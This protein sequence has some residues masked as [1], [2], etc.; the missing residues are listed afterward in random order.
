M[1]LGSGSRGSQRRSTFGFVD[2]VQLHFGELGEL[3]IFR[4]PAS[5]GDVWGGPK[6]SMTVSSGTVS[7]GR[8]GSVEFRGSGCDRAAQASMQSGG[9]AEVSKILASLTSAQ[10][11]AHV[12]ALGRAVLLLVASSAS[13]PETLAG[14]QGGIAGRDRRRDAAGEVH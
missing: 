3:R 6:S 1:R 2:V 4:P 7:R 8:G 12:V 14:F 13:R 10:Q 9:A 11:V 5:C